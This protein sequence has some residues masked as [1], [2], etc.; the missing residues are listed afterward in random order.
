M[1]TFMR[2]GPGLEQDRGRR[3]QRI[4]PDLPRKMAIA[5]LTMGTALSSGC[6]VVMSGG[7]RRRGPGRAAGADLFQ[8][9]DYPVLNKY[10][11][12]LGCLFSSMYGVNATQLNAVFGGDDAEASGT[13][14]VSIARSTVENAAQNGPYAVRRKPT[15]SDEDCTRQPLNPLA[16]SVCSKLPTLS[17]VS[18]DVLAASQF[19]HVVPHLPEGLLVLRT[20]ALDT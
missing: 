8:N 5:V 14:L 2:D 16:D 1:E 20:G 9:R 6:W 15:P 12:V 3:R 11:A 13:S 19:W 17:W 18:A 4:R 10:R 7:H